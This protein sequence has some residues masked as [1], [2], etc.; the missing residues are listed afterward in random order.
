M[1]VER[2]WRE[3]GPVQ[4]VVVN[5][6]ALCYIL[7]ELP[8]QAG[9]LHASILRGCLCYGPLDGS[10]P[11]FGKTV[12]LATEQDFDDYRVHFADSYRDHSQ[13]TYAQ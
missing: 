12:R 11:L 6:Y 7:P 2:Y 13:Y 10:M 3:R 9:I 8:E 4:L 5:E 1:E